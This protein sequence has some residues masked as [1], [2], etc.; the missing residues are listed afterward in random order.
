MN[1]KEAHVEHFGIDFGTTNIAVGGLILDH[2]TQKAFRVLYGEDGVPFPSILALKDEGGVKVRFGRKVK[3]QI[4]TMQEEGYHIIKSIKTELGEDIEFEIGSLRI[5][6]TQ[7]VKGLV[8]SIKKYLA[9]VAKRRV[10]I[11]E[12]TV[13]VPVDFSSVQR[14]EL[15]KAFNDA[16][17]KVN[18]I[19]SES[20]AAY[21][22]NR[23]DVAEFSRVMVFDWGG[24]TLDISLLEV[25]KGKAYEI[26]TSGWKVAGDRI[27][28]IIAEFVHNQLLSEDKLNV[29]TSFGEL[30]AYDK[31]KLL[32][33][34]ER[35]K[36]NFSD[37][38]DIDEPA[39]ISMFDYCGTKS[40]LYRLKYEDFNSLI[41]QT[42]CDAIGLIGD[43]LQQ[44]NK[45]IQDLNAIIMVGGSS[46]LLPLRQIM[47]REFSQKK[48]IK[49]VYPDKPQWSV[50]EGAAIID[51]I[52]CQYELNQ[53]INI[54]MSDGTFYPIIKRGSK[55]PTDKVETVTFGTVD[56]ATSA[57]FIIVDDNQNIL[58]RLTM[59]T[60][61]FFGEYFEVSGKIDN[62][63]TAE[64]SIHASLMM[65][66][67]KPQVAEI[68]KLSYYCDISEIEN[69]K[70]EIISN[71]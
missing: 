45:V 53:D 7:V 14:K 34:C 70:F 8:S 1:T 10:D 49:I 41:N 31:T 27:D 23:D 9:N 15:C 69:Y 20:M 33:E 48:K 5:D 29:P 40:I 66:E 28:E 59:P 26:A 68:N 60:K 51:S 36:I 3:T 4:A 30:S 22:R 44:A 64:I 52:D 16:G 6:P 25:K 2:E 21:I 17:I 46:N 32:T 58:G 19:V 50:A 71:E 57:N 62:S 55:I 11:S 13:A 24:G 65:S 18:K 56:N 63:L 61:G 42:I 38:Y 35:A 39:K 47:D 54:L 37:E 43:V 12:A 67:V